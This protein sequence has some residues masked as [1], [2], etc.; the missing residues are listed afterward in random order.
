[1]KQ[2][3]QTEMRKQALQ[4][5]EAQAEIEILKEAL[6]A[7]QELKRIAE[8]R[9]STLELENNNLIRQLAAMRGEILG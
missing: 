3:D 5:R 6:K 9:N 4:L 2:S 7:T 1:M 8:L